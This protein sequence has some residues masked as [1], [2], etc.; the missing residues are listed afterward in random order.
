MMQ[1][2]NDRPLILEIKG[3][4]LD[5][6][7]G[8]RSVVF[9]KGCPLACSW[10]HNPESKKAG[11]EI[12]FDGK[13]CVD[14]GTCREVC[15]ERALAKD[16]PGYI[17]R[18]R[19]TLCFD[20]TEACPSGALSRV[21]KPMRVG[22]I[23]AG[24]VPDQPFFETSGGGVT[25][26]GG[27]ATLFMDFAS[28]LLRSLKE[29]GI[30]TLLETCG[31]FDGDRFMDR[32]YPYVDTLYFDI[33]LIDPG[34]HKKHCGIGN[35][36]ILDNLAR[37]APIAEKDGKTLLPR[38]PLIPGITDT[39]ANIRGIAEFLRGIGIR[40]AALL[41]YNPLWHEKSGTLGADNPHEHNAAMTAFP[42]RSVLEQ[43][44]K[45]YADAG[46]DT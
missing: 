7:P 13:L 23:L 10:C 33:K 30:H 15:A 32:I 35:D 21:G 22:E 34:E 42:D 2:T 12:A 43:C 4:S 25:L 45:I 24:L 3:N 28:D 16:H 5:D 29:R 31:H 19:C 27:E 41:A 11:P 36:R 17:D 26:S 40:K 14:C 38:T 44:K 8:I 9:F 39:D 46:L 20:C 1:H 18:T 37:L 6:G